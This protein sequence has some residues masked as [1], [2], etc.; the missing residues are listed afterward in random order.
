MSFLLHSMFLG[1][2]FFGKP[3][4]CLEMNGG[5]GQGKKE[6]KGRR[7]VG[8]NDPSIVT[9]HKRDDSDDKAGPPD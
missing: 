4:Q 5:G 6:K 2:L 1:R 7:K 9:P 3:P 8:R